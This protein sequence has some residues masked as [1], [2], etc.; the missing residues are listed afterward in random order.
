ME[1]GYEGSVQSD[2]AWDFIKNYCLAHE[3]DMPRNR[4]IMDRTHPALVAAVEQLGNKA[5]GKGAKLEI[6]DSEDDADKYYIEVNDGWEIVYT[7]SDVSRPSPAFK[8]VNAYHRST[9]MKVVYNSCYGGYGLSEKAIKFIKDYC[10]NHG[11]PVPSDDDF[12]Y[13]NIKRTHPALVAAVET[14][15]NEVNGDFADLKIFESKD[16]RYYIEDYDGKETVHTPS[17]IKW[18]FA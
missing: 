7:P 10:N 11:M 5:S 3:I 6:Y 4:Y 1:Y 12:V 2:L 16:D 9:G 13:H 18:E 15:G 17:N 8:W 14:L